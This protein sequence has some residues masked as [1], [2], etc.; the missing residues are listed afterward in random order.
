MPLFIFLIYISFS[1]NNHLN[2][3]KCC[4]H[5]WWY[6]IDI[7]EIEAWLLKQCIF[8]TNIF[9]W[10]LHLNQVFD[11]WMWNSAKF[12]KYHLQVFK[13]TLRY[14]VFSKAIYALLFL[15]EDDFKVRLLLLELRRTTCFSE[16][17]GKK[18]EKIK[19]SWSKNFYIILYKIQCQNAVHIW[20]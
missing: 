18:I 19:K 9:F 1:F 3:L 17:L 14:T 20:W 16:D 10:K 15:V 5:I 12:E 6:D 11:Q 4:E 8:I 7:D 2:L 13:N